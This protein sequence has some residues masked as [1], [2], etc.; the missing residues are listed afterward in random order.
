MIDKGHFIMRSPP[1]SGTRSDYESESQQA[2]A[3]TAYVEKLRVWAVWLLFAAGLV[4]TVVSIVVSVAYNWGGIWPQVLLAWGTT[5]ALS[6][7]LFVVQ[8]LL[9][10][11]VRQEV[12]DSEERVQANVQELTSNLEQRL[13]TR[14]DEVADNTNQLRDRRWAAEDQVVK[15]IEAD[16]SYESVAAALDKAIASKWIS[17]GFRVRCGHPLDGLRLTFNFKPFPKSGT[18]ALDEVVT[19]LP[20][21]T[22]A[23]F[24]VRWKTGTPA[25]VMFDTLREALAGARMDVS[26]EGFDV[27]FALLN[28]VQ[29][30]NISIQASRGERSHPSNPAVEIVDDRWVFTETGL[31]SLTDG[32]VLPDLEFPKHDPLSNYGKDPKEYRRPKAPSGVDQREWSMLMLVAERTYPWPRSGDFVDFSKFGF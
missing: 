4:L 11:R 1:E 23:G 27:Q 3:R 15:D 13:V 30:L 20:Q 17:R 21:E 28:L 32:F 2:R 19:W 5:I 6:G 22:S 14:L 26:E 7:V 8:R 29:S 10:Q 25:A 9:V 16:A 31:E 12:T 18:P 24:R